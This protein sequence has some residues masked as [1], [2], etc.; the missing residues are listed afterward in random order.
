MYERDWY[1]STL[2]YKVRIEQAER[3]IEIK[4]LAGLIP[5]SQTHPLVSL[6]RKLTRN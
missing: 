4:R 3:N 5:D 6:L 1:A 2:D